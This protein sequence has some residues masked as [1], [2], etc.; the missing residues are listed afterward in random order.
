MDFDWFLSAVTGLNLH[1]FSFFV[2]TVWYFTKDI[3]ADLKE[4][5]N[6]MHASNTRVSRLEG[7]VYGKKMYDS[8]EES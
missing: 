5:K 7:T 4:M 1:T 2:V 6:E 3:R 8:K